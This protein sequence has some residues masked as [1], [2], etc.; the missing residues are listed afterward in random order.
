[1]VNSDFKRPDFPGSVINSEGGAQGNQLAAVPA[2]K[3]EMTVG[4]KDLD[5]GYQFGH[6]DQTSIREAHRH[7]GILSYQATQVGPVQIRIKIDKNL[8]AFNRLE[9]WIN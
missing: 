9:E 6:S 1:M 3:T 4:G 5:I 7:I 8:P 2:I